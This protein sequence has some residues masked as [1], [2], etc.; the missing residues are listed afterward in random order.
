MNSRSDGFNF[1]LLVEDITDAVSCFEVIS[2]NTHLAYRRWERNHV[3]EVG[4][5]LVVGTGIRGE[6]GGGGDTPLDYFH[7]HL[8]GGV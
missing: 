1:L 4:V 6:M 7:L 5:G 2:D 8:G 3:F